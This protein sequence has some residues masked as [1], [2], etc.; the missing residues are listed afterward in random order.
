LALALTKNTVLEVLYLENNQIGDKGAQTLADALSKYNITIGLIKLGNNSFSSSSVV[1][2]IGDFLERNQDLTSTIAE[3]LY[4]GIMKNNE[5]PDQDPITKIEKNLIAISPISC[6]EIMSELLK[7]DGISEKFINDFDGFIN[8]IR[9]FPL[10][11]K[12]LTSSLESEKINKSL[13][14]DDKLTLADHFL[15]TGVTKALGSEANARE[16]QKSLNEL[17]SDILLKIYQQYRKLTDIKPINV[18]QLYSGKT[19]YNKRE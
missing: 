18:K 9:S 3:K 14:L 4:Q 15:A 12:I 2:S 8:I 5:L 10:G 6:E 13:D 1:D 11:S 7:K 16:L 17:E 19:P